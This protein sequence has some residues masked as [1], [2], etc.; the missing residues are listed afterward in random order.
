MP[1]LQMWKL[2]L[3]ESVLVNL[4]QIVQLKCG[5]DRPQKLYNSKVFLLH[6]FYPP[7]FLFYRWPKELGLKSFVHGLS[8]LVKNAGLEPEFPDCYSCAPAPLPALRIGI[9]CLTSPPVLYY[10]FK[11][12]LFSFLVAFLQTQAPDILVLRLS[13]YMKRLE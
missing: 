9:H 5:G 13:S 10:Y 1:S 4:L 8:W 11:D 2:R 6:C 12:A 3:K 7:W